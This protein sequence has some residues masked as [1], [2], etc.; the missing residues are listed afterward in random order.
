MKLNSI[1]LIGLLQVGCISMV[2][3]Q[4]GTRH[5]I[6][7]VVVGLRPAPGHM[8]YIGLLDEQGDR[9]EGKRIAVTGEQLEVDFDPVPPG[10]YAV[11]TYQDENGN[12][13]LDLGL[14]KIPK[15]GVGC[16]NNA[17]GV[18]SAPALKDMLFE[19]NGPKAIGIALTYY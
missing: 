13:Q 6:R 10:R 9:I 11:R 7:A 19:V 2:H 1:L 18:M 8:L 15:E 12:G 16:S 17:Q 5:P 14:F 3:A 4:E